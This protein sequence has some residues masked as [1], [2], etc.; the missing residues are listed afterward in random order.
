MKPVPINPLFAILIL[1]TSVFV[2]TITTMTTEKLS[3]LL[4][5][6]LKIIM[7]EKNSAE[8]RVMLSSDKRKKRYRSQVKKAGCGNDTFMARRFDDLKK[9]GKNRSKTSTKVNV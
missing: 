9:A 6:I 2:V 1:Q 8:S 4:M 7:C 5:V 3:T